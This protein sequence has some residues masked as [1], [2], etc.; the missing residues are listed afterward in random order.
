MVGAGEK[1][2]VRQGTLRIGREVW[3]ALWSVTQ[4]VV[5]ATVVRGRYSPALR[6]SVS[7]AAQTPSRHAKDVR[8]LEEMRCLSLALL[9]KY[10]FEL[11]PLGSGQRRCTLH[12]LL[13]AT[14]L[15]PANQTRCR[16][17]ENWA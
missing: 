7:S 15:L 2:R 6:P 10:L 9:Q 14:L 16:V 12:D 5:V 8:R 17:G 1:N 13:V 11:A 4:F 3:Q